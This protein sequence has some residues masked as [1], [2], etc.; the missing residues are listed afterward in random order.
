M[1]NRK[2]KL[3][4]LMP[5]TTSNT[6]DSNPAIR[7]APLPEQTELPD[8]GGDPPEEASAEPPA[9]VANPPS[10]SSEPHPSNEAAG[11]L[12]P[13]AEAGNQPVDIGTPPVLRDGSG[14]EEMNT[15]APPAVSA[16]LAVVVN[17]PSAA[18]MA[19]PAGPAVSPASASLPIGVPTPEAILSPLEERL[20]RLEVALAM[21]QG[22]QQTAVPAGKSNQRITAEP[23][24]AIPAASTNQI[25]PG[26]APSPTTFSLLGTLGPRPT[27][28]KAGWL[29]LELLAEARVILRMY[30]DPRYRMTWVGRLVPPALLA[31][32]FFAYYCVFM[33][34]CVGVLLLSSE[35]VAYQVAK[36]LQLLIAYVLFKV[37]AHEARRY[38]ETSPDLP[39]SLR[40]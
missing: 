10:P 4:L 33:I 11:A 18:P 6:P 40:P 13:T 30:V 38:R 34:P 24:V 26:P 25:A 29:L 14:S 37:L 15:P 17:A 19:I 39:A 31:T 16:P 5:A 7:L 8:A 27:G 12:K 2:R 3:D 36:V 20:R 9:P 28:K 22:Q 1:N 32:F 23:P 35:T 21:L